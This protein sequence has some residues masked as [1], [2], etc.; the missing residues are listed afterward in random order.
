[1]VNVPELSFLLLRTT[2]MPI[3]SANSFSV[4]K[5]FV[6]FDLNIFFEPLFKI[7]TKLSVCLTDKFFL[8]ILS[9]NSKAL[10][11]PIKIFA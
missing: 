9:A 10:S 1:M 2:L 11:R 4:D 8:T 7:L 3:F 6:S 5:I